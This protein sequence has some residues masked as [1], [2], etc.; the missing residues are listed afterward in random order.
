MIFENKS[1]LNDMI[2]NKIERRFQNKF[3]TF[4]YIYFLFLTYNFFNSK[5]N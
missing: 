5:Q 1:T 3:K 2:Q 4:T